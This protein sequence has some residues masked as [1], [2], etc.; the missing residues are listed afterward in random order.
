[1][2]NLRGTRATA[3]LQVK[4]TA[5]YVEHIVITNVTTAGTVTV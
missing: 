1:M 5:G 3:D 2:D 4:N